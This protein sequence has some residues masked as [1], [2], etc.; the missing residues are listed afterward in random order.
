MRIALTIAGSDSIGGAGVQADLKTFAALGVHGVSAITAVTSQNTTGVSDSFSLPPHVVQ[1]Q[2]AQI[3]QDVT[4]AAVKTGMLATAG[5]VEGVADTVRRMQLPNLVVDPVL[6]ASLDSTETA[7]RTL[8]EPEAVSIL[9]R[10]LLPVA[11]VVT[12]N[13]AEAGELAGMTVDS[14]SRAREAA[15]RIFDLGPAAVVIKGGHM[16]GPQAID[17]LFH[18][19]AFTEFAAPRSSMAPVH[20]TG[21][22]FASAVAAGLAL[23]DDI[24]GAVQRAK[25]YVAGAIAHAFP[26]GHGAFIL[27]HFWDRAGT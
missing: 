10:C 23:G 20:G 1:S 25:N 26:I 13:A 9:K 14:P 21:C 6:A 11:S 8:L 24:P 3:A 15:R 4:I 16:D 17:L 5:I 7:G 22:A 12:P 2:I 19:G 27:N 18:G